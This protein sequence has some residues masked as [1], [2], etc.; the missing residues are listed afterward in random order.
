MVCP[1]GSFRKSP[2]VPVPS[3]GSSDDLKQFWFAPSEISESFPEYWFAPSEVT[4]IRTT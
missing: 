3:V 4:T 1:V 2:S